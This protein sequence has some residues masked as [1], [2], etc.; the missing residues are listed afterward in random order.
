MKKIMILGASIL[1]VPAIKK[2]KEMGLYVI[3]VDMDKDA[4]GFEYAD[5]S[6]VIS[7]LDEDA[8]LDAARKERIDGIMTIASD[9]PMMTV[10]KVVEEMVLSGIN[11]QTALNATNKTIMRKCLQ[12]AN[13]PI[14]LFHVARNREEF[15][16]GINKFR[17]K[18][19]LK[20]ADNSGSRGIFL[21]ENVQNLDL[22]NKAYD[23]TFQHSHSG[24]IL[25][26]EFMEGPEVSVETVSVG[27]KCKVI[28]ITDKFTTGAP[29]FVEM[30][31]SQPSMLSKNICKKIEEITIDAVSAVGIQ[32]GPAH[33]EII[34]TEDGPKIVELGARLGGD[35]ITSHLVPLSTGID[36]IKL[37]ILCALGQFFEIPNITKKASAIKYLAVPEGIVKS[38]DINDEK[39]SVIKPHSYSLGIKKGEF[40]KNINNSNDRVG[41][42]IAQGNTIEEAK[43][44]CVEVIENI[45]IEIV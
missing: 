15:L 16:I 13:V 23:Y 40:V 35:N 24:D 14:P 19:I 38:V 8:V 1:Q 2:A 37:T 6:Y 27:G 42:V 32:S 22:I 31:H 26:E 33:T 10:A 34:V 21:I 11:C 7:T 5:K 9:R 39:I 44:K 25:L 18:C 43:R 30:G 17:N 28:A 3:A 4:V 12:D 45:K 20:P 41:Y 36:I 29:N